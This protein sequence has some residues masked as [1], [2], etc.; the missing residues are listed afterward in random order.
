MISMI[1]RIWLN[2]NKK[3]YTIDSTGIDFYFFAKLILCDM[4]VYCQYWFKYILKTP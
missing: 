3:V 1:G 2:E 4:D